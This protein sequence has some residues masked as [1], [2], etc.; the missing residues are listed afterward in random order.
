M[1]GLAFRG[2]FG[3]LLPIRC[4]VF[5]VRRSAF[6]SL[7]ATDS[8]FPSSSSVRQRDGNDSAVEKAVHFCGSRRRITKNRVRTRAVDVF[9]TLSRH[10][11]PDTGCKNE[12]ICQERAV[13]KAEAAIQPERIAGVIGQKHLPD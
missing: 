6:V 8:T 4:S 2:C 13:L 9:V 1:A 3:L 11:E 10:Q 7:N 12:V 5:D